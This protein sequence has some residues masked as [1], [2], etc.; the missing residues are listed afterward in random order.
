MWLLFPN[1]VCHRLPH[2]LFRLSARPLV[3]T[4][5]CVFC[6]DWKIFG[7]INIKARASGWTC[8]TTLNTHLLRTLMSDEFAAPLTIILPLCLIVSL[9]AFPPFLFS[10]F[11][12][13]EADVSMCVYVWVCMCERERDREGEGKTERSQVT[14]SFRNPEGLADSRLQHGYH[15]S[16][17]EGAKLIARHLW[18][19]KA[20]NYAKSFTSPLWIWSD[21]RSGTRKRGGGDSTCGAW[22]KFS[23]N[24]F[25]TLIGKLD[26]GQIW[27]CCLGNNY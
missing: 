9:T 21:E 26:C 15:K 4:R 25:V 3:E 13:R 22:T 27:I 14:L 20:L 5:T 23:C 11:L 12:L 2:T 19:R 24:D 17:G 16:M 7:R 8:F 6:R 10:H 1:Y 18:R